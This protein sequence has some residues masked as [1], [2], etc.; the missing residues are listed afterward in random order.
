MYVF[1]RFGKH[2]ETRNLITGQKIYRFTYNTNANTGK[3]SSVTDAALNSFKVIRRS[4]SKVTFIENPQKQRVTIHFTI[5]NNDLERLE[6]PDGYNITFRYH[7]ASGLIQS[8]MEGSGRTYSYEYDDQG[9]LVRAI[10]PT[11]EVIA[12]NFDLSIRGAQVTAT[13]DGEKSV[14]AIIRGN[15]ITHKTGKYI[16]TF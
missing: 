11:G 8:K 7:S 9:R 15:T 12:L 10:L 13:R 2:M 3:L 16:V 4:Y 6:A 14:T 1:N 5:M